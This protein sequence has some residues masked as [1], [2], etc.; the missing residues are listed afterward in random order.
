MAKDYL[1]EFENIRRGWGTPVYSPATV[2]DAKRYYTI[3]QNQ[4][5]INALNGI[6][7]PKEESYEEYF[8]NTLNKIKNM[9]NKLKTGLSKHLNISQL[10]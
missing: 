2:A 3:V 10:Y 9:R 1:Q 8:K 4:E 6:A 5:A 7:P